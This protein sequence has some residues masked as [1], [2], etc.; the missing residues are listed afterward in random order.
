MIWAWVLRPFILMLIYHVYEEKPTFTLPSSCCVHITW[1]V[2]SLVLCI[3]GILLPSFCRRDH[4][5]NHGHIKS[6]AYWRLCITTIVE[7]FLHTKVYIYTLY[8]SKDYHGCDHEH[9]FL[10]PD[11]ESQRFSKAS[12]LLFWM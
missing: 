11:C 9:P 4:Q 2:T 10:C 7:A 12:R 8:Y 6:W 1:I 3:S 5:Y